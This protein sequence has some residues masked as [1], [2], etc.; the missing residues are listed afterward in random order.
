VGW[1]Q[2]G[3]EGQSAAADELDIAALVDRAL[4]GDTRAFDVLYQ[5]HV[6]AVQTVI[7]QNVSNPE[8]I[9]DLVQDVFV[10]AIESLASLREPERFRPWLMSI[11]RH[12]SIDHLRTASRVRLTELDDQHE[13]EDRNAG[14][15]LV[16]EIRALADL[17]QGLVGG[18]RTR[19]ATAISLVSHLSFSPAEVAVALG[20]T[21]GAAKVVVHRAR[22]RL[23]DALTLRLLTQRHGSRQRSGC[24]ELD[25]LLQVDDVA[26]GTRHVADCELCRALAKHEADLEVL[27]FQQPAGLAAM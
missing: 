24:D 25:A 18:L 14:P 3:N 26:G 13:P 15:E 2:A 23:R 19:D 8:T 12:A 4:H 7:R 17:V 5:H 21:E 27:G 9:A 10:R 22:R 11:A 1:A 16:T 6:R 20:I